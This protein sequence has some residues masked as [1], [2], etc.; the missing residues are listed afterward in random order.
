MIFEKKIYRLGDNPAAWHYFQMV[1][2]VDLVIEGNGATLLCSKGNLAFHFNGGRDITVRGLTLDGSEPYFTQGEVVSMDENGSFDV[3]I[4]EGYPEPPDE[5][6]LR[7]NKHKAHGGGGRHM[8]VFEQGGRVRNI[9]MGSDHLYI[10][11]ISRGSPGVFRFH[12]ENDYLPH[13]KGMAVGNWI[14][15]GFNMANLSA[16]EKVAK[17]KS[18]SIYGQIAADRVE[19]IT[20]E[21]INIFGSLNGG[22]R[23][24]DM[25]GDV[26]IIRKPGTRNLLSIPSDALH[27]DEHPWQAANR[28]LRNRGARRRLPECRNTD[29]TDRRGLQG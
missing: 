3:K 5:T 16:A 1:N 26:R 29:G 27:P 6:F 17:H 2:Q 12:V 19:N 7:A 24:S 11:N 20:F 13:M 21:D 23:V 22:I 15:Y 9:R 25:P 28:K 10:S 4:M 18:A 8:I 14:S